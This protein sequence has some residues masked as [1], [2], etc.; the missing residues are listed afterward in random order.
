M[1]DVKIIRKSKDTASDGSGTSTGGSS[2]LVGT[3]DEAK[4]AFDAD[5]AASADYAEKSGYAENAGTATRA[6]TADGLADDYEFPDR[7]IRRDESDTAEGEMYEFEHDVQID[8]KTTLG[9]PATN[10]DPSIDPTTKLDVWGKTDH[11]GLTTFNQHFDL[12]G[13]RLGRIMGTLSFQAPVSTD[14]NQPT[15]FVENGSVTGTGIASLRKVTVTSP[16]TGDSLTV[17][18]TSVMEDI[19]GPAPGNTRFEDGFTGHGFRMWKD[20]NNA[21][22]VTT[23]YLTVRQQM[24]VFELLIQKIRSTAGSIVVSAANGKIKQVGEMTIQ[25]T[26]DTWMLWFETDHDFTAGDIIRVQSWKGLGT[27]AGSYSNTSWW[28][29][30]GAVQVIDNEKVVFVHKD[31][32]SGNTPKEGDEVVQWGNTSVAGRDKILYLTAAENDT[33][34]LSMYEGVTTINGGSLTLKVGDLSGITDT[35]FGQLSGWGLYAQNV[36]L[37][38]D[39]IAG[40]DGKTINQKFVTADGKLESVIEGTKAA[41][42]GNS[43][44]ANPSMEDTTDNFPVYWHPYNMDEVLLSDSSTLL[45]DREH[46]LKA[47]GEGDA[48]VAYYDDYTN[49]Y[50][51][52]IN[53]GDEADCGIFQS[54]SDMNTDLWGAGESHKAKTVQ[55]T[56]RY[57][58]AQGSTLKVWF[59]S[60]WSSGT[61]NCDSDYTS[62][63]YTLY[64]LKKA[65]TADG[66]WHTA[67]YY[68]TFI[69]G[70]GERRFLAKGTA[71]VTDVDCLVAENIQFTNSRFEQTDTRITQEVQSLTNYVD[72]QD[73]ML[74]GRISTEAGRITALNSRVN[75]VDGRVTT[76]EQAG[77]VSESNFASMFAIKFNDPDIINTIGTEYA[78]NEAVD[79]VEAALNNYA[80]LDNLSNAMSGVY[81]K[82]EITTMFSG[83]WDSQGHF[84]IA[85]QISTKVDF[86]PATNR[87]T[88]GILLK[89][90]Q[91]DFDGGRIKMTAD[92]IDF[93]GYVNANGLTIDTEGNVTTFGVVNNGALTIDDSNASAYLLTDTFGSATVRYLDI[94][95]CPP[96]VY[97]NLSAGTMPME[98]YLPCAYDPFSGDTHR[99][100]SGSTFYESNHTSGGTPVVIGNKTYT[101]YMHNMADLRCMVGKKIRMYFLNSAMTNCGIKADMLVKAEAE[102]NLFDNDFTNTTAHDV[103]D[104]FTPSITR[105][106]LCHPKTTNHPAMYHPLTIVQG[107]YAVFE[108]KQGLF[109]GAECIYWERLDSGV[110]LND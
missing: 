27:S 100:P 50:L 13:E 105:T 23:D 85:A 110:Y 102:M 38:S 20:T 69:G 63:T 35:I 109:N 33:M 47:Y 44:V 5:R 107:T 18:G 52:I 26:N 74:N 49:K 59:H 65:L 30:V 29:I 41:T 88:G 82:S 81:T 64:G 6:F 93:A 58:L 95:R 25:T 15:Q 55:F 103:E 70:S 11:R 98:I 9:E 17:A 89:A 75:S 24:K 37:R 68:G 84:T 94:L 16:E 67:T 34:G 77:F 54:V 87:I 86:D 99:V 53:N 32:W 21:Y 108:C 43:I 90:D 2:V 4:H 80:T 28:G 60:G 66:K 1:I 46:L 96:T 76:I 91:L 12:P 61:G 10:P 14:P 78:T 72:G 19:I 40:A 73:T 39:N 7:W 97:L 36:Y 106:I 42:S 56:F 45:S 83:Y 51:R 79:L 3:I 31:T 62:Q 101:Q 92:H 8:G 57:R 48:C 22:H 71:D 104:Q